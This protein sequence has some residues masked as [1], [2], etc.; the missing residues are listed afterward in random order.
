[1]F[2][3]FR[4]SFDADNLAF[5]TWQLCWLIFP[6]FGL[7]SSQSFG[8]PKAL[9]IVLRLHFIIGYNWQLKKITSCLLFTV[10]T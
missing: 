9:A 7:V 4:L 6:N 5:L 10:S 1:M 8:D 3:Y 2:W